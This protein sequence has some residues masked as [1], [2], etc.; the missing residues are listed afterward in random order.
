MRIAIGL[1]QRREVIQL[2]YLT[3]PMCAFIIPLSENLQ[4]IFFSQLGRI[5]GAI[6]I[7]NEKKDE[8]KLWFRQ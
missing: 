1:L 3:Q 2:S 8:I 5:Y 4:N 7:H 6:I